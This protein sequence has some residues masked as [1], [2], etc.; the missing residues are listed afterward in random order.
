[1]LQN[2]KCR[3]CKSHISLLYP[4]IELLTGLLFLYSYLYYSLQIELIISLLLIAMLMIVLV[5]DILYLLIPNKVLLCFLPVFFIFRM[6]YP[7]T[8]WWDH[9]IGGLTISFLIAIII[10]LSR[11]GMGGGD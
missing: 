1:L 7:I 3:K 2:G 6:V 9:I 11:G 10:L 5:S 8:F 4:L